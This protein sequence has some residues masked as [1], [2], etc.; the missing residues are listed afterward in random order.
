[1]F[2]NLTRQAAKIDQF[3]ASISTV[4]SLIAK[5][6]PTATYSLRGK[7]TFGTS[8][9]LSRCRNTELK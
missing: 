1:M 8:S 5:Q 7:L 3:A 6:M 2:K 4:L 9:T